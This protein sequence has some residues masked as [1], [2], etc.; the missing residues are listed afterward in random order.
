MRRILICVF[1]FGVAASFA[2]AKQAE[3]LEQLKQRAETARPEDKVKLYLEVAQQQ[4][5]NADSLYDQG[6]AGEAQAAV[7]DAVN[8]SGKARDAAKVTRKHLKKAEIGVR[9]LEEK[10]NDI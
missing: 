7:D 5:R 8:Y 10:L 3:S 1:F 9:K 4:V 2:A 6:K